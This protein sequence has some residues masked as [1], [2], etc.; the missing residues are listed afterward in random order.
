MGL[1]ERWDY[2]KNSLKASAEKSCGVT[3][4]GNFQHKKTA[5]SMKELEGEIKEK[6]RAW[7]KYLANKNQ[8]NYNKYKEQRRKVKD[9][10]KINKENTWKEFGNVLAKNYTDNQKLFFGTLKSFRTPR[11]N[12]LK[13]IR[14][15]NGNILVKEEEIMRRWKRYFEG[16]LEDEGETEETMDKSENRQNWEVDVHEVQR[17]CIQMGEVESFAKNEIRKSPGIR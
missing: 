1:E 2:F 8:D 10:V 12:M 15:E 16:L 4:I 17:D 7:K 13:N 9:I 5:R 11:P 6:K 3:R 14:D